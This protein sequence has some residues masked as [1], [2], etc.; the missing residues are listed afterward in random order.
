MVNHILK[1]QKSGLNR[2]SKMSL[3]GFLEGELPT[4]THHQHLQEL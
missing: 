3:I 1:T 2:G 4:L